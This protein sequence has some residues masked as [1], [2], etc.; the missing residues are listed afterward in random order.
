MDNGQLIIDNG[1]RLAGGK[2]ILSLLKLSC[3]EEGSGGGSECGAPLAKLE[4]TRV[5]LSQRRLTAQINYRFSGFQI[6][7]L[8]K[9]KGGKRNGDLGNIERSTLSAQHR[10]GDSQ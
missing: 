7:R 9:V 8:G 10:T 3:G 1:R 4:L 2:E 6:I 5:N